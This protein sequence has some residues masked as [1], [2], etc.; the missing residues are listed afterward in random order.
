MRFNYFWIKLRLM[1]Y[2]NVSFLTVWSNYWNIYFIILIKIWTI[3]FKYFQIGQNHHFFTL[4][5]I[6][7]VLSRTVGILIS[8]IS[9]STIKSWF[10]PNSYRSVDK[11]FSF[12]LVEFWPSPA[13]KFI[14]TTLDPRA[15]S[16]RRLSAKSPSTLRRQNLLWPRW[17]KGSQMFDSGG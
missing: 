5:S 14:K 2:F 3:G 4:C 7:A 11:F 12:S 13:K 15:I 17:V 1:Y 8:S 6:F 10:Y 16:L 9:Y